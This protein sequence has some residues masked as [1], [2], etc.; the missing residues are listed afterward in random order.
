M[1][2][3][4]E[5]MLAMRNMPVEVRSRFRGRSVPSQAPHQDVVVPEV[6]TVV[7]AK[8]V[9]PIA[10]NLT[11]AIKED[12]FIAASDWVVQALTLKSYNR[13]ADITLTVTDMKGGSI[14]R[15]FEHDSKVPLLFL[16]GYSN[17]GIDIK[18]SEIVS[19]SSNVDTMLMGSIELVQI[20]GKATRPTSNVPTGTPPAATI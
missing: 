2:I 10:L 12:V 1:E 6:E 3:S 20:G 7:V 16:S 18:A 13:E 15:L 5:E 11:E 19:I 9:I 8:T 4:Q 17:I 14:S